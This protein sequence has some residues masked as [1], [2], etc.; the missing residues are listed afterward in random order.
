MMVNAEE[1]IPEGE[2]AVLSP[3]QMIA[4]LNGIVYYVPNEYTYRPET[5]AAGNGTAGNAANPAPE[6]ANTTPA[7]NGLSHFTVPVINGM[8]TG[9]WY[10][11]VGAF[12]NPKSV[13][14]EIDRIGTAYPTVIQIAGSESNPVY[15]VLLGPLSQGESGAMLQRFKSIGY[16]DAFIR[17]N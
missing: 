15:R 13:E 8:E 12:S 14:N 11:Q 4:P 2:Q 3:D 10:V 6:T 16:K 5:V 7:G 17:T 9:M 1:R